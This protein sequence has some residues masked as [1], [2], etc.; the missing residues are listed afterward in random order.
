VRER[1]GNEPL[2]SDD[3]FNNSLIAVIFGESRLFKRTSL[4]TDFQLEQK[5]NFITEGLSL[6]GK[7]S[8]DNASGTSG[9]VISYSNPPVKWIS[10]DIVQEI[11]PGMTREET[12]ELEEEYTIW[13]YPSQSTGY[14]YFPSPDGFSVENAQSNVYRQLYYEFALNYSHSFGVHTVSGLALMSRNERATGSGFTS[15]REDWVGRATYN[16][17]GR[18]LFEI[19]AA[20]N[21]SEKFSREYRFGFFPSI[22]LGWLVSNEPFFQPATSMVNKLKIRY[23]DGQVGSDAGI[24]RWLYVGGWNVSNTSWKFGIPIPQSAYRSTFEGNIPNPDIYWEVSRKRNIAIET[25]FF[26]NLLTFNF[27]YFWETRSNIFIS[28]NDRKIPAY[29]GA[30]PVP[31]NLGEVF[32]NGWE[33]ESKVSK[34][35]GRQLNLW[36]GLTW[37]FVVDE[38]IEREDPELAP[39]YQKQEGFSIGQTRGQLNQPDGL[40][41]TWNDMYTGVVT[42]NNNYYLPGDF[43]LIDFNS[44]GV[45]NSDDVIPYGYPER[46]MY[47]YS[48]AMGFEFNNLRGSIIFYGIYNLRGESLPPAFIDAVY[49]LNRAIN[50]ESWSPERGV[51]TDA[52]YAA[53]RFV[54]DATSGAITLSRAYL[55]IQTVEL[56]YDISA[57]MLTNLGLSNMTIKLSGTNLYTWTKALEDL[58]INRDIDDMRYPLLRRVNLGLSFN[59]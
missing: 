14:D 42:E 50:R 8:Y 16:Y 49:N 27:D 5:L 2:Y 21:G 52:K 45:I 54:T 29:F 51:T 3:R 53:D 18:Y 36:G 12:N 43:H 37:T 59:F 26:E 40:I 32:V 57:A 47:T 35:I 4:T 15:Y 22:A 31:G 55:K 41:N 1:G 7:I 19:N 30:D 38:I 34:T 25:G 11:V 10:H 13:D 58:D 48:P 6:K 24:P 46:P 23:S 28:G 56:A 9:P 39:E 44:N 33:F 17:D 20:Y